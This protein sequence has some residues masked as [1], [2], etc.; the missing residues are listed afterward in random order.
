MTYAAFSQEIAISR[1]TESI[2]YNV[3]A[4]A[5]EY[6]RVRNPVSLVLCAKSVRKAQS[7]KRPNLESLSIQSVGNKDTHKAWYLKYHTGP[8]V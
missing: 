5:D 1:I 7:I 6:L 2:H 8:S 4:C 3:G